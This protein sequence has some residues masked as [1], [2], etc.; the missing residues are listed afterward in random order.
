MPGQEAQSPDLMF[1]PEG[2]AR[3]AMDAASQVLSSVPNGREIFVSNRTKNVC[4]HV[5]VCVCVCV[6][7]GKETLETYICIRV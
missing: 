6:W 7:L 1:Q 2:W 5:C 4:V 3:L